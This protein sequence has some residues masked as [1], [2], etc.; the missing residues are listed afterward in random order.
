MHL[1]VVFLREPIYLD[2]RRPLSLSLVWLVVL[3][4]KLGEEVLVPNNAGFLSRICERCRRGS[5][6]RPLRGNLE[7]IDHVAGVPNVSSRVINLGLAS[8][9]G[10]PGRIGMT[11]TYSDVL[12]TT[13]CKASFSRW[14]STGS[15]C[16]FICWSP[17][18]PYWTLF[19]SSKRRRDSSSYTNAS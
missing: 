14:T 9:R 15:S 8:N 1:N 7:N 4:R 6:G 19:G 13:L 18:L 5:G 16:P 3:R 10:R 11:I 2:S 17:K 12:A